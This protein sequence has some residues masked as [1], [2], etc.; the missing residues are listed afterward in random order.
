MFRH[1]NRFENAMIDS[2][3]LS[4]TCLGRSGCFSSV[5]PEQRAIKSPLPASPAF[6]VASH[7]TMTWLAEDDG[8]NRA[9]GEFG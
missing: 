3:W 5:Q 6:D 4:S 8:G 7:L 2:L 1:R 9:V